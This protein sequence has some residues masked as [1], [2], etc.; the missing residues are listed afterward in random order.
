V[1]EATEE[2]MYNSLFM[3]EDMEGVQGHRMQALPLDR[4]LEILDRYGARIKP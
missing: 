1:V 4:A 2:A 3:A